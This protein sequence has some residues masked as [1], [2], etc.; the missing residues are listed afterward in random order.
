MNSRIVSALALAANLAAASV[1]AG[2]LARAAADQ[3]APRPAPSPS[4]PAFLQWPLPATGK[5]YRAIDGARLWQY[6]KDHGDIAERYRQQ[7]HPQFWGVIAGTSGDADEAQWLL[8]QYK[9]IGLTDAHIQ[10]VALFHPQWAPQSCEVV[11]IGVGPSTTLTSA[12]P[13]Y[14][15]AATNGQPLD[16]AAAYVGLG[17]EADLAGRDVRGKAV[18]FFREGAGSSTWPAPVLQRLE[19]AGAAAIF[20]GDF[21]GGNLSTQAYRANSRVP[22]FNLGTDDA[23]RLRDS[24]GKAPAGNSPHVKIRLD[25]TWAADQKSF[26]VW[27]TLP[28]ATDE[29][30]YVIAHRDGWFHASGDNA[31]GV[32]TMLGLAEYYANVPRSQ[33]RRTMIFIGTDGHHANNPSG[34]GRE[35]L[36]ANRERFFAKTALMINAE[37]PSQVLTRG[38]TAGWTESIVPLQW[39]AG[40]ASRPQLTTIAA[41]A[42][43]EFGVPLW[44]RPSATPPAGDLGPFAGFLPGVVLQSN[45]FIYMHTSGDSPATVAPT[46]LEAATRA[47]ARIIDEVNALPL[48]D[49]QR[50]L[51]PRTPRID[52]A[53]CPAWI[54]DSSAACT[55][56]TERACAITAPGC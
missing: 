41:A 16:L 18:L 8:G 28:G 5:A 26:L 23:V 17:S 6:V 22:T 10:T 14:A 15:T 21:R 38:G 49:L 33:R 24:I 2:H 4:A 45:D 52:F 36:A 9:R 43:R 31:S 35:W 19:S 29:T 20:M 30:I 27:G 40:G 54:K 46:G 39:Y 42:F 7:G 11:Q 3:D 53:S 55:E 1:I 50:P 12:Q 51:E 34:Y 56:N 37:H 47:Y 48:R 32:A 25:A 44:D 13:A